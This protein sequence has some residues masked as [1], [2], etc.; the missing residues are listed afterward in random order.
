MFDRV[1]TPKSVVR[2]Q[3]AAAAPFAAYVDHPS[4]QLA[5]AHGWSSQGYEGATKFAC[6]IHLESFPRKALSST[7]R[8][9]SCGAP[10]TAPDRRGACCTTSR[11]TLVRDEWLLPYKG[12]TPTRKSTAFD[13]AERGPA[14]PDTQDRVEPWTCSG[15]DDAGTPRNQTYGEVPSLEAVLLRC[16]RAL[17]RLDEYGVGR[18][19]DRPLPGNEVIKLW[20]SQT[21]CTACR[22][23]SLCFPFADRS[24]PRCSEARRPMARDD[25]ESSAPGGRRDLARRAPAPK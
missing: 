10:E 5:L 6:V 1:A 17:L 9:G 2:D 19:R 3:G 23:M 20:G 18:R 21:T 16:R 22:S 8:T 7:L 25:E 24:C 14:L 12:G 13:A 4:A 15:R 11:D